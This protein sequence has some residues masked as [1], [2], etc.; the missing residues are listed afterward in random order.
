MKMARLSLQ[1]LRQSQLLLLLIIR[2]LAAKSPGGIVRLKKII[3]EDAK[4]EYPHAS[5][6]L[7]VLRLY[8]NGWLDRPIRGGYRI[9]PEVMAMLQ[10]VVP[11]A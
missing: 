6:Q 10:E 7:A 2:N 3:E 4:T 11:S 9:K 5:A 1:N 8:E